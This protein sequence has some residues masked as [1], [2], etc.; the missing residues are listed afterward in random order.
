MDPLNMTDVLDPRMA[1]LL[2]AYIQRYRHCAIGSLLRGTI[3]NLN[4][5]LQILS[6][7]IELLQTCL[8][9]EGEKPFPAHLQKTAQCLDQ[10]QK[11]KSMIE[12][13]LQKGAHD[14][15]DEPQSIDLNELLEEELSI[16]N[17]DLFV[18][19][20]VA[21]KKTFT[22]RL[23]P[24]RGYPIDFSQ[25]LSNLI[26]NAIEAM[27][28]SAVKEL[29]VV[30]EREDRQIGIQIR[31]TGCGLSEEIRPHLF[32]PFFTTKGSSHPGL[33]LF[34]SSNILTRYG[35]SFGTD[36]QRE[37]TTFRVNFPA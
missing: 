26:Q 31:D 32:K 19:H 35:A 12:V 9:R 15:E 22:S 13:L 36:F 25:G 30:T 37:N 28:L 29:T 2:S 21:I 14:D 17:H 5:A 4:G 34:I 23:P 3:H 20:Q 8:V 27:E 6:M 1:K 24:L 33:G 18:K 16:L 7:R 10:V 11:M